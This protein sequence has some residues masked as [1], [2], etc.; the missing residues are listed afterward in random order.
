MNNYS[1]FTPR[2]TVTESEIYEDMSEAFVCFKNKVKIIIS[3]SLQDTDIRENNITHDEMASESIRQLSQ[4]YRT[5][6]ITRPEF[7]M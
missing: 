2:D 6:E 3:K 5:R 4:K 7:Q 1:K